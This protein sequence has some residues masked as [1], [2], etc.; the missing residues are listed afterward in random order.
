MACLQIFRFLGVNL[1]CVQFFGS[2][3]KHEPFLE[4]ITA[5]RCERINICDLSKWRII[6]N[7]LFKRTLNA[8]ILIVIHSI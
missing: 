6:V 8:E 1:L 5:K 3:S 4:F 2:P 7:K